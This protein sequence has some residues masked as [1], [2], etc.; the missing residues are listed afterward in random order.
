MTTTATN[1][2]KIETILTALK[3]TEPGAPERKELIHQMM[4]IPQT[5]GNNEYHPFN[6]ALPSTRDTRQMLELLEELNNNEDKIDGEEPIWNLI[7]VLSLRREEGLADELMALATD[8][9]RPLPFRESA[10]RS[11]SGHQ[12]FKVTQFLI[13]TA[14]DTESTLRRAAIGAV[15]DHA[16]RKE[17]PNITAAQCLA[18]LARDK[19]P[20]IRRL[21]IE[22]CA[23]WG[24]SEQLLRLM[25]TTIIGFCQ[26]ENPG[27]RYEALFF[28]AEGEIPEP[29]A[30]NAL[31]ANV[32]HKNQAIAE[33]A[34]SGLKHFKGP[35]T[36][37]KVLKVAGPMVPET[38]DHEEAILYIGR[39]NSLTR[40]LQNCET[41][42][43]EQAIRQAVVERK[44]RHTYILSQALQMQEAQKE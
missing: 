19:D 16:N 33:M 3:A 7:Q 25:T 36:I 32:Y 6:E 22:G 38:R 30:L 42:D 31:L 24:I 23:N 44:W 35:D 15:F 14:L 5:L 11:L 20:K 4:S 2:T 34:I 9:S 40:A 41:K 29:E 28:L 21:I 13:G 1:T 39:Q 10:I 43:L 37:Q 27:V 17:N 26:D 8:Q 12:D 18:E